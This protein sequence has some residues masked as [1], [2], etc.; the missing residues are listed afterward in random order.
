MNISPKKIRKV[1]C[2]RNIH[3]DF[4]K[5]MLVGAM[6]NNMTTFTCEWNICY[7]KILHIKNIQYFVCKYYFT[8]TNKMK[9]PLLFIFLHIRNKLIQK[10]IITL[11][12]FIQ[13]C[14]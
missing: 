14:R 3:S 8:E 2:F 1:E 4:M 12:S 11:T 7:Y 9:I 6:K 13:S 5:N 10:V